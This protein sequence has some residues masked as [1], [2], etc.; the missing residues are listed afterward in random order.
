M[1]DLPPSQPAELFAADAGEALLRLIADS[2][3]ALIAY[4]DVAT[5]QCR[6]AN[7]GYTQAN[8]LTPETILG[9]LTLHLLSDT[10]CS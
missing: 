5:L 8:G 3:P 2:V 7:R 4:Y 9:Q 10:G 6:F 1:N